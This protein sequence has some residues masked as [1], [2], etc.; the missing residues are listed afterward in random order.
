LAHLGYTPTFALIACP[1]QAVAV[2]S[3]VDL[4]LVLAVDM[5]GSMDLGEANVQHSGYLEALRHPDFINAADT[6]A[7]CH[8][9][10]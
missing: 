1:V 2:P 5:S 3:D 10:F 8:R 7:H 9:L 4:E 6:S